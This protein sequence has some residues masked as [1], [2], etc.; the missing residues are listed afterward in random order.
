[1]G[2]PPPATVK[3]SPQVVVIE[4]FGGI[5]PVTAALKKCG[6]SAL[7]FFSEIASDPIEVATA[8]WP[9][10]IQIG[11]VRC[12]KLEWMDKVVADNPDSLIWLTGGVPCKDV[13]QLNSNRRGASGNH[14]GK[15]EVAA[16]LLNHLKSLT[17]RMAFTFE[18]T[19]MDDSDRARFSSAFGIEPIEINN[20]GWSPLSRPRWWWIGGVSPVWPPGTQHGLLNGIRRVRPFTP[21]STWQDCILPGFIPCALANGETDVCF[22]CLTTRTPKDEQ[23]REAAGLTEASQEA[24]DKWAEDRWSQAP[25]QYETRNMVQDESGAMRRLLPCEEEKLMGYPPDYTAV[26]KK[27]PGENHKAHAYRRQTLL[28]NAWSLHVT[29][30]LAQA[31]IIPHVKSQEMAGDSCLEHLDPEAF[32]WG[33]ENCPYLHDL[34]ERHIAS[35]SLPPDWT[36]MNAHTSGNLAEGVQSRKH[37][38][39]HLA[40]GRQGHGPVASLPKGLPPSIHFKAGCM[41]DSPLDNLNDIPDDLEFAIRKTVALGAKADAWRRQQTKALKAWLEHSQNLEAFWDNLRSQNSLE[42]AP[43]VKPHSLDLLGHSIKWPDISIAAMMAA[44]ALPLGKQEVTGVFRQK[45]TTAAIETDAF[46]ADSG[47]FMDKMKSR[48]PPSNSQ[49]RIIY[50]LSVK[51][52]KAE[53]LSDWVSEEYLD[54]KFTKGRWRALPR[55]AIEQGAKWRLIDNGKAGEHNET[56][57]ADET[58]HSTC[59]SA[60]VCVASKFRQTVG[61]PLRKDDSLTISTQDMWKAYR[62]VPCHPDQLRF[63]IVMVWHPDERKWVYAESKGLLFGL[64]GA[65]LAFNRVPALIVALARRWLAIPVQN[66]FDDFRIIDIMKSGGSANKF[67]CTF[68]EEIIGFKMDSAKEQKPNHEAIFLGNLEQ[69]KVPYKVDFMKIAPKPGRR[70][71][72]RE[73]IMEILSVAKLTPGDAKT[74]RGRIIHYSSTCAGRVGKGILYYVNEQASMRFAEWSEGLK[75]NL[76]YLLEL[77][78][79]DILRIISK[80]P[81]KNKQARIWTDASFHTDALGTPI[82]KLCGIIAI[83]GAGAKG[84]V[85]TVPP[86]IISMFNERKQQIH[87]GELLA[88]VCSVLQWGELIKDSSVIFYI[89]NMG[90]LCN[91]VNGSAR[92]IDAGTVTFAL[93]LQLATLRS[94]VWWEWVE[95]ESNC[96]DGGS[97]DGITCPLAKELGIPLREIKFPDIPTHFMRMSPLEWAKFWEENSTH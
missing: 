42:V 6:I 52:Q 2:K 39:W 85:L 90:V 25:Y 3:R 97:R 4:L 86:A 58:I 80:T 55:Y 70:E 14:S 16:K 5:L 65:V 48:P 76:L 68:V 57:S 15:Y 64:T 21:T 29:M 72:I 17:S 94:S 83:E 51:E 44:G 88:P 89:D 95:S 20:R 77:L 62:Q 53:L 63:M 24:K 75:F 46:A 96:S 74:L 13:S 87:M 73:F 54:N 91:L 45:E 7:S 50:D 67:F 34:D 84:I 18:C 30:F 60:G 9:E 22:R 36:E 37:T 23:P 11:D 10:A 69:Y 26:L 41:V 8:H 79:L 82:C 49:A 12:L 19:R 33:R 43:N 40:K 93:H 32:R 92:Q 28:G 78:L 47:A 38:P 61:K 71:S 35:Q 59:T 56:Y 31:L 1:M 27:S 66:F 81:N